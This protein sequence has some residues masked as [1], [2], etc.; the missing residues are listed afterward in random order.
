[1]NNSD[2]P[3]SPHTYSVP[4]PLEAIQTGSY[5]GP[6]L[7]THKDHTEHGLTKREAFA[8]AAM[9]GLLAGGDSTSGSEVISEVSAQMADALLAALEEE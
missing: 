8:M 2:K 7:P 4:I 6:I 3:A 5:H 1:M 9:Q